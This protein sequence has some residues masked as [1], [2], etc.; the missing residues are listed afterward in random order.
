MATWKQQAKP[1]RGGVCWKGK[2]SSSLAH[3]S[4]WVPPPHP[5]WW[6]FWGPSPARSHPAGA[7]HGSSHARQRHHSLLW[8]PTA[9][10]QLQSGSPKAPSLPTQAQA[11]ALPP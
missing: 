1:W 9:T 3:P 2:S 6:H 7:L 5:H 10:E 11:K 4:P 8:L